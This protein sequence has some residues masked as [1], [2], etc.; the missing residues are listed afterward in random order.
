MR[1]ALISAA[2]WILAMATSAAE[3]PANTWVRVADCPG[4]AEGR[5]VPPGR[6][7]TWTY[8]PP[9][10]A[11]LRYGG[12]TPRYSNALDQFDPASGK[13]KRLA[14]EDE[15]YPD[16][17][18]GGGCL[19]AVQWDERRKAV[20]LGAG[21]AR[22]FAGSLGIWSYD[23]VGGKFTCLSK[24]L[25]AGVA[26]G[27]FDLANGLFVTQP[28]PRSTGLGEGVTMVFTLDDRKWVRLNTNPSPQPQWGGHIFPMAFDPTIGRVV[29]FAGEGA[30][31]APNEVW[32]FDGAARKW[33]KLETAPGGP[34]FRLRSV[35]ASDPDNKVLL[36]HGV[37]PGSQPSDDGGLNDTWVLDPAKKQWKEIKTPGPTA[38]K[39]LLKRTV[40]LYRQSLAYDP[41][42]K[43]FTLADPDLGVWAFRYDPAAEPGKECA[44]GGFVPAVGKAAASPP[45][46]GAA[47]KLKEVRLTLPSPANKRLLDMADNSLMPLGGGAMSGDEIG[48]CWDPE[49]AVF[50]KYGGCGNSQSP[51]WSQYG[52]SLA[53]YDPGTERWH[54]RRASD[55]SG[56]MRPANG[57]TRS[58]LHDSGRKGLW[59]FGGAASGP[60]CPW[61]A[62]PTGA[63][64]YDLKT[65]RFSVVSGNLK[66]GMGSNGCM[67]EEDP[68][69]LV[70]ICP[71][72][73]K[74][75]T[76]DMKTASWSAK[77]AKGYASNG[78]VYWRMA[79]IRSKKIFLVLEANGEP[80]KTTANR[81]MAYD[82]AAGT[83]TD[84]AP[85]EHPSP[86]GCKYGLVYDS[87]N[88]V[89]LLLGGGTGWNAG[90]RCDMWA[91]VV[92]DNRWEKISPV[93][94]GGAKAPPA[95]N[96]NMPSGYDERHNAVIFLE[97]NSP[98]AYRYKK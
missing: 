26:R 16:D 80:N 40:T 35:M 66:T 76:F 75:H 28:W 98:W 84:L 88:D 55:V 10:K 74:V 6:A 44:A 70:A 22:G 7:S 50:A 72:K 78:E 38:M 24:D 21:W 37:H 14:A 4:D 31:G 41:E 90:W 12:Y 67:L 60:F 9:L 18:P 46:E 54:V 93:L 95:F 89:A 49:N 83:W 87:K 3:I 97:G 77:A 71:L 5:E 63:F 58:V 43:R 52:N 33:E 92:K 32:T 53:L 62:E 48:W 86:R 69:L 8:C 64:S 59:F 34:S 19:W 91:Y 27:C 61:P 2:T 81:T 42:L 85:K 25:P 51:F 11:F 45:P 56:A 57:C 65:D 20:L 73:D 82:P 94:A 1:L 23:P 36:L 96:D 29:A 39:D 47:D 15:N 13:W 68:D 79:Y 30:K 17:R